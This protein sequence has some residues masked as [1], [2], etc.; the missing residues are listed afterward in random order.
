MS[1]LK[2]SQGWILG[3]VVRRESGWTALPAFHMM[4]QVSNIIL[5]G[6]NILHFLLEEL[7]LIRPTFSVAR[8]VVETTNGI[9]AIRPMEKVQDSEQGKFANTG[10]GIHQQI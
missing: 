1:D 3:A 7:K 2:F 4:L 9:M 10:F 8:K 5:Q 6:P